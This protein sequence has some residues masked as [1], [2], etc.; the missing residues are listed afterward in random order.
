[1]CCL[2]ALDWRQRK[3]TL[4]VQLAVA[5]VVARYLLRWPMLDYCWHLVPS[6]V[7]S[8]LFVA[9]VFVETVDRFCL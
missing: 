8:N 4:L 7:V 6:A 1:M 9:V 3:Q 5:A 2:I